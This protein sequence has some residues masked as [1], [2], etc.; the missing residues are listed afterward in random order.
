MGKKP[1][2][3][4]VRAQAVAL[5]DAGFRQV[6]ISKQLNISRFCVQ[7]AI[8][9]YK[10][11]GTYDDLKRSGRLKKLDGRGFRHLKRLVKGEA[12]LS[13][14]KIASDLNA[15]LQKPVTTR[16][17]RTYLRELGFEYVVKNQC[18][19]WRLE[20]ERLLPECLQQTNTG[21]GGKVGIWGGIS[22]FGTTNARIYT[23]NTNGEL[24][25]DVLQKEVKQLLTKS[26]A[27]RKMVFQQD[28]APWH[29]SNI[30]KEKIIR[31]KLKML[32]W[33]PKSPDLNPVEM[34][35][36]ILDKKLASKPIYS[37]AAL[38]E[39]LQEEW[40]NVDKDLCIKLVES[41]PD[42]IR[43]CLKAKGGHFV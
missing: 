39:R 29:T 14:T 13:A 31:L 16:T 42:R 1:V 8:N 27:Q 37:K 11:L 38:V 18:K 10:C 36:S 24:Y 22:G 3:S 7:K 25:C 35:W 30:V 43:K 19:I 26:P 9:K 32:D 28:L 15:S 20:K 17:V 23:E 12:R 4:F 2:S 33:A 21:D 34:L 6:Q 41:M 40:N 5:H